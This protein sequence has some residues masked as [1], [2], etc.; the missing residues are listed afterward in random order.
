VDK[1]PFFFLLSVTEHKVGLITDFSFVKAHEV[2]LGKLD[3]E[4]ILLL[5]WR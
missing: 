2:W 5:I 1:L 3:D 4:E